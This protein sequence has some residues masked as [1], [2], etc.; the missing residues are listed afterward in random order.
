MS[1]VAL[2]LVRGSWVTVVYVCVYA[3]MRVR[4]RVCVR[5]CVRVRVRVRVR[6]LN[7]GEHTFQLDL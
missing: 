2:Y 5:V 6:V 7:T 4:V 3:C 1:Q